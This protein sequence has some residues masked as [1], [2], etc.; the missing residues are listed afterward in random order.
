MYA[1]SY[2]TGAQVDQSV[3]SPPLSPLQLSFS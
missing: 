1:V 3:Q 2:V